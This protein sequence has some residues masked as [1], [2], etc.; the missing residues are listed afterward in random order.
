MGASHLVADGAV[1]NLKN[2]SDLE[3]KYFMFAGG[4]EEVGWSK[5]RSDK[6]VVIELKGW[7]KGPVVIQPEGATI[8]FT[9]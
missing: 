1:Y 4:I 5:I 8:E 7:S 2:I 9:K 3:G 6:N